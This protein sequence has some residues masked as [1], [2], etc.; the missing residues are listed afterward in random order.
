MTSTSWKMMIWSSHPKEEVEAWCCIGIQVK[1][2]YVKNAFR[3]LA[4]SILNRQAQDIGLLVHRAKMPQG[5][6]HDLRACLFL[7]VF[8]PPALQSVR[9]GHTLTLQVGRSCTPRH[10][11]ICRYLK[12]RTLNAG[13][14]IRGQPASTITPS[15]A[16]TIAADGDSAQSGAKGNDFEIGKVLGTGG[17]GTT[18]LTTDKRTGSKVVLKQIYCSGLA[19]TN[20]AIVEAVMLSRLKHPRVVSYNEVF[21]GSDPIKGNY[22]G[23][24]MEYCAGGDLFQMLCKQRAKK[25]KPIS[26]RRVKM[27]IVQLCE[28]LAYLH[29]Q[30]VRRMSAGAKKLFMCASV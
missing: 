13:T 16:S 23:I 12:R 4:P 28:A 14:L 22:V 24:V 6:E 2:L 26:Q 19:E 11:V 8:E 1:F 15:A 27:W 30:E 3:S 7:R 17:Q 29:S 21:L 10:A 5:S 20:K 18:F 9:G 25:N